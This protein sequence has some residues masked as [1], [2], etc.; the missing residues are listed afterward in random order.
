MLLMI[1]N[2]KSIVCMVVVEISSYDN[3]VKSG[4]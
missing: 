1:C 3:T 2:I 4:C